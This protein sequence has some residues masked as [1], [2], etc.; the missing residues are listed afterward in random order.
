[1]T[2][3]PVFIDPL[4]QPD[5]FGVALD[6]L[7]QAGIDPL[8]VLWVMPRIETVS[9]FKQRWA[10]FHQGRTTLGPWVQ[11]ADRLSQPAAI[12]PWLALQAD[13]VGV[14]RELPVLSGGS[15]RSQLW[16]LAQEYLELALRLLLVQKHN[17]EA[18]GDYAR[19]NIFAAEEAQV[20]VQLAQTYRAELSALLP[21]PSR[22]TDKQPAHV[23]WFDDG[24][25]VPGLWLELCYPKVP[26][27]VFKLPAIEGPQPWKILGAARF[28]QQPSTLVLQL[29]PDETTQAQQAAHQ[30]LQWL[31]QDS[32]TEIAVA[33]LDRLAARRMVGLL[34]DVGVL[35]DDRTGWRLST[36]NVA[37]WFDRLLEQYAENGQLS[38][39]MQP[40]NGLPIEHFE[41]WAFGKADT[42]YTLAQWANAFAS[43]FVKY[44]LNEALQ[45][46]EAGQQLLTV[47]G[48]MQQVPAQT[49]FD[50][51]EFLAA[52]RSWAES[53]R[54]RPL[55]IESPVRMVPLLSTRMRQFKR[56][57]VLGCAQSHFQ[58]SPP[59]LLPPAVAQELGFPGPR[60]AR[61]QK[62]SALY[63][64]LQYSGEVTLL[65]SAQVAGKP[66]MLLPEL[67]WLDIVLRSQAHASW[68]HVPPDLEIAVREQ[69]ELALLLK[70][71]DGGG[72]VP[73]SIRVTSLDD[74]MACRLRFGLKHALPWPQQR[75]QGAMRYEQL[76]GIFVHKVLEKTAQQMAQ[77]GQA[78]NQLDAWKK[79][80]LDQAQAV[81][82]K[83]ELSERAT[84][85]PFLK[86]FDQIV[87]RVAG[88]LMERQIQG[89]QFSGAEKNIDHSLTLQPSGQAVRLNGRV[90]RLDSRGDEIAI[91][92]IKF[93]RPSELKKRL[94]E[95]LSQPQLPA[96]QAMLQH[97]S[98]QLD[99]LGLH[100]DSVDWVS[101]PPLSDDWREFG[102]QSW[103]EVLLSE[104]TRELDTF[105]SGKAVWQANPGSACTWCAVRGVCR[106]EVA[107]ELMDE[108]G[109]DE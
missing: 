87:P 83:L 51:H 71:L 78:V 42:R 21:K 20:V 43:L 92:D 91:S 18:F 94:A 50:A 82:N 102:F 101:F 84:V 46:D 63:E 40:F 38:V 76:R 34:A 16:G 54:F 31:R 33:V 4:Q 17:T 73:D 105:F 36:S 37:G 5:P 30:I 104:L 52:W 74:W 103:G 10:H 44:Q 96:Y 41:P 55:D 109:E 79:T 77:P 12:G 6:W 106:P 8:D 70:A 47:L 57:L 19:N 7:A 15:S 85:Y 9:T 89:W 53:Q 25:T 98:A 22:H 107:P 29:A 2:Q 61:I 67:H 23:L 86:F 81:W 14:L 66:E 45:P 32:E 108:E 69:P 75:E 100:K 80:L 68:H 99:F 11:T 39:V 27:Q 65:H 49:E 64:L 59:G 88:K 72:S 58:E 3:H 26:V 1:M 95:P 35:V 93:T 56:V 13:L 24:E 28:E 60:L 90:D 62:I 97:P 48:L